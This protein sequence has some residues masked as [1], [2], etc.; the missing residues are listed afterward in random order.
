MNNLEIEEN[1]AFEALEK[2][3]QEVLQDL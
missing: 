1:I 3:F 2:E